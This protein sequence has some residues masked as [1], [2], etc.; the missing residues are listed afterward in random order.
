M[1]KVGVT[2]GIGAGKTIVTQ[3]F[4]ALGAPVYNADQRTKWLQANDAQLIGETIALLGKDAYLYGT[5]NRSYVAN[6]VFT[7]KSLLE[8]YNAIVHPRVFADFELW[9]AEHS[10]FPYIIKESA[11]MFETGFYK[12]L[13]AIVLVTAPEEIRIQRVLQRDSFRQYEEVKAIISK[14]LGDEQKMGLATAII[15][16]DEK[17][18]IVPQI[19]ALDAQFRG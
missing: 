14:Q 2:G 9:C 11:L 3:V 6:K 15:N 8:K 17:S 16:N 12:K 1:K 13:D 18:L 10:E 5:L 4:A 19:A 7:D